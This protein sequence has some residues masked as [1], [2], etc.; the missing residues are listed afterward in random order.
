MKKYFSLLFAGLRSLT[1]YFVPSLQPRIAWENW[2]RFLQHQKIRFARYDQEQST[3]FRF[4]NEQEDACVRFQAQQQ[5]GI[6]YFSASIALSAYNGDMDNV[7]KLSA[8][9]NT[10]INLG[11]I[12]VYIERGLVEHQFRIRSAEYALYPKYIANDFYR[13]YGMI[14]DLQWA[15]DE[16]GKTGEDP[17]FIVAE[18]IRRHENQAASSER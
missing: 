6:I 17:L 18:L 15:L 11:T 8:H 3:E 9:L 2:I 14:Q 16:M 1:A 10:F 12:R 5:D 4:F 7:L 13:Q